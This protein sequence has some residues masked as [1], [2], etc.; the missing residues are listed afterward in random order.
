MPQYGEE[1]TNV[2]TIEGPLSWSEAIRHNMGKLV[3]NVRT[4]RVDKLRMSKA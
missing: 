3:G 2:A 1:H 4:Y